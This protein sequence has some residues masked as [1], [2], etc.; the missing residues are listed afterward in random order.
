MVDGNR[1]ATIALLLLTHWGVS[2]L[3]VPHSH[4]GGEC[5]ETLSQADEVLLQACG[6]NQ[7]SLLLQGLW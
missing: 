7:S 1:G 2:G 5:Q 3:S 6:G 4:W